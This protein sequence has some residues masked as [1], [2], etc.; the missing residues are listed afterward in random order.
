MLT[1]PLGS[2]ETRIGGIVPGL[3][4]HSPIIGPSPTLHGGL[5]EHS[6]KAISQHLTQFR[7]CLTLLSPIAQV[8]RSAMRDKL[9]SSLRMVTRFSSA[10]HTFA[11]G[12]VYPFQRVPE[13]PGLLVLH[14]DIYERLSHSRRGDMFLDNSTLQVKILAKDSSQFIAVVAVDR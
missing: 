9:N 12:E 1:S 10:D 3:T 2:A 6:E 11:T 7:S 4:R 8:Q 5:M 13:H 14:R